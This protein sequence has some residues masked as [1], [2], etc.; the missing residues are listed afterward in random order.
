M[1]LSSSFTT[2]AFYTA[3]VQVSLRERSVH[4]KGYRRIGCRSA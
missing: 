4:G 2:L 3:L 1:V